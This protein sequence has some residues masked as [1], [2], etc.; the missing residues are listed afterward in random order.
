MFFSNS[1]PCHEN[2]I[3]GAWI[4]ETLGL[5]YSG[6][7]RRPN[8]LKGKTC[9]VA[10]KDTMRTSQSDL[11]AADPTDSKQLRAGGEESLLL[12]EMLNN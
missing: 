11:Q 1:E 5:C 4:S 6:P 8:N 2:W 10:R 12:Y 7:Q 3:E 9:Q